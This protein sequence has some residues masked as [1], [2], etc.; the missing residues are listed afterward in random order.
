MKQPVYLLCRP[1]ATSSVMTELFTCSIYLLLR[2]WWHIP[3]GKDGK[4][5]AYNAGD[6]GWI[7][8]LG[9][10][11]GK[12]NGYPLQYSHLENSMSW[13]ARQAIVHGLA[14]SW[15]WLSNYHFHFHFSL[16]LPGLNKRVR[17]IGR[18]KFYLRLKTN[19]STA[20]LQLHQIQA[21]QSLEVKV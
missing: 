13:G 7:P 21:L 1:C 19:L 2:S 8:R 3:G 4:E 6:P 16:L 12:G 15:T 20:P 17:R 18:Y 11:P 9:R 5:S 10:S 14:E